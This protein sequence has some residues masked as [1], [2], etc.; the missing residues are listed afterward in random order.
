M[1]TCWKALEVYFQMDPRSRRNSTGAKSSLQND[2]RCSRLELS[3]CISSSPLGAHSMLGFTPSHSKN[4]TIGG[5][6]TV[7]KAQLQPLWC[8]SRAAQRRS[9]SN[10]VTPTLIERTG[11]NPSGFHHVVIR[12]R[13]IGE[14][15][16]RS[17]FT[18][19]PKSKQRNESD[20]RIPRTSLSL[21]CST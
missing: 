17:Y 1:S 20:L 19:C 21:C 10:R 6:V 11:T 5:G 3:H 9:S 8:C 2:V 14:S 13:F 12:A 15:I 7:A 4:N 18:Y 16:Y